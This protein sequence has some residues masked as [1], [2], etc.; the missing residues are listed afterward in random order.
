MGVSCQKLFRFNIFISISISSIVS[1]MPEI[2]TSIS[3][4]LLVMLVSVVSIFYLGFSSPGLPQF[5]ITS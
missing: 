2:L 4:I 1:F 3:L 5:V